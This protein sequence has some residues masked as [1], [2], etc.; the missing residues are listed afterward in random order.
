M[1]QLANCFCEGRSRRPHDITDH[2]SVVQVALKDDELALLQILKQL[3]RDMRQAP[4]A[5]SLRPEAVRANEQAAVRMEGGPALEQEAQVAQLLVGERV[6]RPALLVLG[7]EERRRVGQRAQ[8]RREVARHHVAHEPRHLLRVQHH[9]RGEPRPQQV[10]GEHEVDEQLEAGVV[11]DE[12]DAAVGR[13]ASLRREQRGEGSAQVV[14][15]D[16][17][18]TGFARGRA[19]QPLDVGE[20]DARQQAEVRRVAPQAHLAHLD[21][22]LLLRGGQLRSALR[23]RAKRPRRLLQRCRDGLVACCQ[24]QHAGARL[25]EGGDLLPREEVVCLPVAC[26]GG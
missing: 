24:L 5:A 11:E 14:D 20:R 21:E 6:G 9:R 22:Q 16:V 12:V 4:V 23:R 17:L 2:F 13:A 25:P 3:R 15:E 7:G 1:P 10:P 19:L 26:L 8:Q 18:L